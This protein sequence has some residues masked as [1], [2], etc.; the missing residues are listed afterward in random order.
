M[1]ERDELDPRLEIEAL[2]KLIAA[3]AGGNPDDLEAFGKQDAVRGEAVRRAK[4]A[5]A[6]GSTKPEPPE[7][8]GPEG[9]PAAAGKFG[10]FRLIEELGRGGQGEVWLAQDSRLRRRVA[11]KILHRGVA[12]S[13]DAL[14]RFRR[15]AEIASKLDHPGLCAVFDVGREQGRAWMAMRYVEGETVSKKIA[16]RLGRP[17]DA[18]AIAGWVKIVED[19]ARA[20]HAAHEVGVVHRDLKPSN[21]V[22]GKD[23]APVVLDFGL[24]RDEGSGQATLTAPGA[25]FG[26]PAFMAPEQLLGHAVIDRR[27]DV[28]ALGAVLFQALTGRLP[29][30][31]PTFEA[32]RAVAFDPIP[33][34][35]KLNPA[36]S[37]DLAVV[38]AT[39]LAPDL[40]LRYRTAADF[41]DDLRRIRD[42]EP[43][44]ARPVGPLLR[45]RSWAKRNKA[46]AA[47]TFG[48]FLALAV[49]LAFS[50]HFGLGQARALEE[51]DQVADVRSFRALLEREEHLWPVG[52]ELIQ[53]CRDWLADARKASGAV[54]GHRERLSRLRE[55]A[56]EATPPRYASPVDAY[57]DDVLCE[58]LRLAENIERRA[59]LVVDRLSRSESLETRSIGGA[60]A[61][62]WD[63][64]CAALR[65]D[66][67][68]RGAQI[69]PI[70]GLMPLG[71]DP[72]SGLDEFLVVETGSA[73]VDS[74]V[75]ERRVPNEACGVVLVLLPGGTF[76]MGRDPRDATPGVKFEDPQVEVSLHP[77]LLS[78]YELTQAQWMRIA[79]APNPAY[80]APGNGHGA[81]TAPDEQVTLL[82]PVEHVSA[83]EAE[84]TLGRVGLR[85][86][87][88]AQWEYAC[89]AGTAF[90]WHSGPI[91][92][93]LQGYANIVGR[94]SPRERWLFGIEPAIDDGLVLHS[95]IGSFRPNGFGIYDLHGNVAE[96]CA[97]PFLREPGSIKERPGDG[98]REVPG[99]STR[100]VRGGSM[101][102]VA[103]YCRSSYRTV[104]GADERIRDV[105]LRPA[106]ALN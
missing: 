50:L 67:R 105:G 99:V 86:P 21:V 25:V 10:A 7:F 9:V 29:R 19:T 55:K 90:P 27:A 2:E 16:A 73:P 5:A 104:V 70:R 98:F 23:G 30:E 103:A 32:I 13:D 57:Y 42:G 18:D 37:E 69:R 60:H 33:T 59:P 35:R 8:P 15:E 71:P 81:E 106:R 54:G 91:P 17:G 1:N 47:A 84:K 63:A 38:V 52:P 53:P 49:G 48:A 83:L 39:A 92:A 40:G 44:R 41:A 74:D 101:Q 100:A 85:L 64:R 56:I 46:L 3:R 58:A 76:S 51:R 34:V 12:A 62:T 45:L 72:S 75:D 61:A 79:G 43:V 95:P 6:M 93:S 82:H 26:T 87:T 78:K 102:Q 28:F 20:V 14:L 65:A 77:F 31:G 22:V 89:R 36:V 80:Y 94:E 66:S 97:D 4:E 88:E 24:A 68:F 11:L 96:W